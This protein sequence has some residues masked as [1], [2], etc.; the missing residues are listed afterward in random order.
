MYSAGALLIIAAL[1]WISVVVIR[2]EADAQHQQWLRLALWRMDGYLGPELRT[3]AT[4]PNF[5]Y[6]PF[7]PQAKAYT[8]IL[9]EIEPGEVYSPSPLL[10]NESKLFPLH[11]QVDAAGNVTSPQVPTGNWRDLAES[12]YATAE[13]IENKKPLL[14]KVA[15]LLQ[16]VSV[17][18]CVVQAEGVLA[19]LVKDDTATGITANSATVTQQIDAPS[20]TP[21]M[22]AQSQSVAQKA[23]SKADLAWRMNSNYAKGQE[24]QIQNFDNA[25]NTGMIAPGT[26]IEIGMLVPLWFAPQDT[27][28][29][30][31]KVG[32]AEPTLLFVRRV[33]IGEQI[34]YQGALA[35][36]SWLRATLTEQIK[37]LFP[38]ALL[39]PA[40]APTTE[41]A[42][43]GRMLG[44]VPVLLQA[45]CPAMADGP[46]VTPART[47]LGLT[48]LA[49]LG[50]LFAGGVS[51]RASIAYGEKRSRFASAVT[52]ELRTPL[53]TFRMYSE[54]L[55]DGMV[56]DES[57]RKAY[58]D[59]LKGE[60]SRLAMLVENVLSYARLEE[61]G[62]RRAA[63]TNKNARTGAPVQSPPPF[64]GGGR[65]V[66]G[67][68]SSPFP[69]NAN[70]SPAHP[71]ALTTEELLDSVLPSLHARAQSAAMSLTVVNNAPGETVRM[72]SDA[73]AGG[74][75][76][77]ILF[78]LVDN[79]CK[80]AD[81]PQTKNRQIEITCTAVNSDSKNT[82]GKNTSPSKSNRN[83][84]I[85]ITVR[86]HGPGVPHAHAK[87][88][89][90]PFERG[91][92]QPGDTIP[93]VGLGL[94]LAR[95]LARDLGGDLI[96]ERS[97]EGHGASFRLTLPA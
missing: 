86:D 49:A 97:V 69:A 95:G 94:A 28:A 18:A 75:I 20:P 24:E 68:Q 43:S 9:N 15:A 33:R 62:K 51:L 81:A 80:Y 90:K 2:L 7:Y 65:G 71:R 96:L 91:E 41:D 74:W 76:G 53:T 56:K 85:T 48:W 30:A 89:F 13:R 32:G 84:G 61:N 35:D 50:A 4:R 27:N 60:S 73:V 55:A 57:Q 47:A 78:N 87:A 8:K 3:E 5:E 42:E 36:W 12:G 14:A 52:H 38:H 92:R 67:A 1:L 83:T 40:L 58:L 77:Q 17:E 26:R 6:T 63:R 34:M 31:P 44:T 93:G 72:G 19:S 23:S 21:Q 11:F 54:M 70:F 25:I 22:F 64:E 88:I 45:A 66:G 16:P 29:A 10:T 37:D 39:T 79:A 82:A 46:L 59:T